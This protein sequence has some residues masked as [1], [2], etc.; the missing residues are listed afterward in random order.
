MADL[1]EITAAHAHQGRAIEACIATDPIVS[2]GGERLIVLIEPVLFGAVSMFDE[3]SARVPVLRF[4]G[5]VLAAFKDQDRLAGRRQPLGQGPTA[6]ARA[7]NN[8]VEMRG[9]FS[10]PDDI[11]PNLGAPPN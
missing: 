3:H 11:W 8:D 10:P 9:Q 5:N 2:V 1:S 7:H 6:R 4:T